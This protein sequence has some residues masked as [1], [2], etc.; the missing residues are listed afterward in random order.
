MTHP[1]PPPIRN[2]QEP[3]LVIPRSLRFL[4]AAVGGWVD[5]ATF[6]ALDGLMAAHIT[7]NLVL[8]AADLV[9]GFGISEG[10]R[11]GAVPLFF[12][13]VAVVTLVHDRLLLP[14]RRVVRFRRVFLLEALLLAAAGAL[15]LWLAPGRPGSIAYPGAAL[16]AGPIVAA[17]ALQNAAHRL[18]P[19]FGAATTVMTGNITQFFIDRTRALFGPASGPATGADRVVPFV[20]AG[21]VLGCGLSAFA[22]SWL[23]IGSLLIPAVVVPVWLLLVPLRP[24]GSA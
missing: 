4:L 9:D 18:F 24:A 21:F 7:G 12:L 6:I 13:V 3:P 17:M 8:V 19:G 1:Q 20:I 11:L 14:V 15:W 10:L 16:V 22:T 23:G 2:G 5:V